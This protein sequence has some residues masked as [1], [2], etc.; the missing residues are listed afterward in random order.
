P[1]TALAPLG[2]AVGLDLAHVVAGGGERE[3]ERSA[4]EGRAFDTDTVDR[5][6]GPE[7]KRQKSIDPFLADGKRFG[8]DH[9]AAAIEDRDRRGLLVRVRRR[10]PALTRPA[11]HFES[12]TAS[13]R[14]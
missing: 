13:R 3:D 2:G 7:Q 10:E 5:Q 1:P 9:T 11:R 14:Q 8:T 4:E 6:L 12:K